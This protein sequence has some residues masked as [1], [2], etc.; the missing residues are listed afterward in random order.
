MILVPLLLAAITVAGDRVVVNRRARQRQRQ[1]TAPPPTTEVTSNFGAGPQF[2]SSSDYST[3]FDRRSRVQNAFSLALANSDGFG[4]GAETIYGQNVSSVPAVPASYYD[5]ASTTEV[6]LTRARAPRRRT[7]LAR[8]RSQ[9]RTEATRSPEVRTQAPAS[10]GVT[11]SRARIPRRRINPNRDL[12]RNERNTFSVEKDSEARTSSRRLNNNI[13][14][15]ADNGRSA[16][17]SRSRSRFRSRGSAASVTTTESSYAPA[18]VRGR[19]RTINRGAASRS[20]TDTRYRSSDSLDS[21]YRG[22]ASASD[23]SDRKTASKKTTQRPSSGGLKVIFPRK[24]LFPKLNKF[25]ITQATNEVDTGS[26]VSSDNY[27]LT[28]ER[29]KSSLKKVCMI[30]YYVWMNLARPKIKLL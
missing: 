23:F 27:K 9:S 2:F 3:D 24:D 1:V 10:R 11:R 22:S 21:R 26:F 20:K 4:F 19:G 29:L 17:K 12:E 30:S 16:A 25:S 6:T 15:T 14:D 18:S 7:Q 8:S 28:K 13:L 5:L